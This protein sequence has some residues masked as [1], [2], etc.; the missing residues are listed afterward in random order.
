MP[1]GLAK[2]A[3]SPEPESDAL[4]T[5]QLSSVDI[6]VMA[7]VAFYFPEWVERLPTITNVI[8]PG[9]LFVASFRSTYFNVLLLASQ[10]R[11]MDIGNV[12]QQRSGQLTAVS[13]VQYSWN[14][15]SEIADPYL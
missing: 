3:R 1:R 15:S 9:G 6:L 2:P 13:D 14:H 10:L 11:F 4:S 12:L 7:E 5:L 8:R